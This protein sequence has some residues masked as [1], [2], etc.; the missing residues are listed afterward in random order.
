LRCR[1]LKEKGECGLVVAQRDGDNKLVAR[2]V[3]C[4]LS[5]PSP[6]WR[7]LNGVVK[8]LPETKKLVIRCNMVDAPMTVDFADVRVEAR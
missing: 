4:M 6:G 2:D 7:M 8:L 1:E 5:A 3:P